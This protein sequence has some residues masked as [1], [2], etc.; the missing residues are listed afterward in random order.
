MKIEIRNIKINKR[1]SEETT[2]FSLS[3]YV[4]G[5]FIGSASNNGLGG[6]NLYHFIDHASEKAFNA[7]WASLP[8]VVLD[9]QEYPMDADLFTASLLETHQNRKL[10]R[11]KTVFRL[12]SEK[13]QWMVLQKR[14]TPGVKTMLQQTYGAN[15]VEIMNETLSA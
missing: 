7:H 8:P 14:F 13:G 1:L 3:L 5:K 15:L 4:D 11:T 9:G 2:C 10:C 12:H 6:G